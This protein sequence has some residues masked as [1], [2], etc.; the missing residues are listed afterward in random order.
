MEKN[1]NVDE[2]A[3]AFFSFFFFR[4]NGPSGMSWWR[5]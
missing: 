1:E 4:R 5:K 2:A 3:A